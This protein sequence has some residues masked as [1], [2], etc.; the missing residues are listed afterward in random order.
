MER[1]RWTD[2]RI[3]ERMAAMDDSFDR[4]FEELR[5]LRAE[6]RAGFAELRGEMVAFHRQVMLIVAGFAVGLLGLLGAGQ[7]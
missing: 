7:L 1:L 3:D 4:V 5:T 6:T 2:E